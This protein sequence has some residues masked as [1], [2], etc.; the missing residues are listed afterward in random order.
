MQQIV[1]CSP[2]LLR[3]RAVPD[4]MD[5]KAPASLA[6][7]APIIRASGE[8]TAR[9]QIDAGRRGIRRALYMSA[10]VGARQSRQL[11]KTYPPLC[12]AGKSANV[13]IAVLMK[14]S[15]SAQTP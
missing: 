4:R 1:L 6:G 2:A 14:R 5:G 8:W 15:W 10:H 13:A 12:S 7:H 11:G 3:V 9:S